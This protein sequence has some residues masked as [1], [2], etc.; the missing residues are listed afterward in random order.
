MNVA[1]LSPHDGSPVLF[2]YSPKKI[3]KSNIISILHRNTRESHVI[4]RYG[5]DRDSHQ[6]SMISPK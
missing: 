5:I 3:S 6:I 2:R 1:R 4:Y